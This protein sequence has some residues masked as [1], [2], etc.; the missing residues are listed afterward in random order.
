MRRINV[1]EGKEYC[2]GF[3]RDHCTNI[4]NSVLRLCSE[5]I[6]MQAGGTVNVAISSSVVT[7][8]ESPT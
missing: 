2:I 3:L 4:A 7:M 6:R 1:T 8:T 5:D